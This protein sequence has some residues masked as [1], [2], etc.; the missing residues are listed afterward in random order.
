[1]GHWTLGN[2]GKKTFKQSKQMKKKKIIKKYF[3]PLQQFYTLYE[4]KFS[5]VKPLLSITFTQGFQKSKQL[6]QWTSGS[7]GEKTVKRSEKV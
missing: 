3:F 7:G 2:E 5:N 1:M 6:G 4:Q